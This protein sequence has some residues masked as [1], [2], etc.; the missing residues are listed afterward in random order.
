VTRFATVQFAKVTSD[1]VFRGM[2]SFQN[3]A[4]PDDTIWYAI[5][6]KE[7]ID[8]GNLPTNIDQVGG[9]FS[10]RQVM[11]NHG[12]TGLIG[13]YT[14]ADSTFN[15]ATQQFDVPVSEQVQ[16]IEGGSVSFSA[17]VFVR[18]LKGIA[19]QSCTIEDQVF[20]VNDHGFADGDRITFTTH[21]GTLPGGYTE[22]SVVQVKSATENTFEIESLDGSAIAL[23]DGGANVY[24]VDSSGAWCVWEN[25]PAPQ[26]IGDGEEQ[27]FA[28]FGSGGGEPVS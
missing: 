2:D 18:D 15:S 5:L 6:L 8:Q 24:V 26:E 9:Y 4:T 1:L 14:L 10:A 27:K 3:G 7:S 19:P 21:D 20:T 17:Y 22:A 13:P 25:M 28:L 16:R 12:Y 11:P 23:S